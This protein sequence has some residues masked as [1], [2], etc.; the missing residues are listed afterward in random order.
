MSLWLEAGEGGGKLSI[1]SGMK[2]KSSKEPKYAA[3]TET[4][5]NFTEKKGDETKPISRDDSELT[6]KKS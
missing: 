1:L 4:N 2:I 6:K 3:Q 5:L